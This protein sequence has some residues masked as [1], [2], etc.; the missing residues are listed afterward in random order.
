METLALETESILVYEN[1]AEIERITAE[2]RTRSGILNKLNHAGLTADLIKTITASQA[3]IDRYI[4]DLQLRSNRELNKLH[5]AGINVPADLPADLQELKYTLTA[6]FN[7]R[8]DYS[9]SNKFSGL[10]YDGKQWQIDTEQLERHFK[11]R[12]IKIFV[13]GERLAEFRDIKTICEVFNRLGMYHGQVRSSTFL[14]SR[15]ENTAEGFKP[16]GTFF[17]RE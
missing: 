1:H 16:R 12:L 9:A 11:A 13:E 8:M 7:Y 14:N 3:A 10:V 15:I 4:F 17:R 2:L 6:W 5:K